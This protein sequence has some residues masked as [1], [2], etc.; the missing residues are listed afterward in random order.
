MTWRSSSPSTPA[1][2]RRASA[3][4]D[5]GI[6]YDEDVLRLTDIFR[7][8]GFLV[9]SVVLTQYAGQGAADAFRRRLEDLGITCYLHYPIE[10]Y[11]HDIDAIVSEEG[12]GRND[13]IETTRPLVVVTAPGP[14]SRQARHLPVAALP[15]A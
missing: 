7:S 15:R 9:S 12:Y 14:G 1:T 8:Y 5:L 11:P 13:Y 3:R 4:S 2:S 10:G 6:T